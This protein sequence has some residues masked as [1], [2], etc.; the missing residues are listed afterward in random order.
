MDHVAVEM[1]DNGLCASDDVGCLDHCLSRVD[2]AEERLVI[3]PASLIVR[4]FT[5]PTFLHALDAL[6][7]SPVF[8]PPWQSHRLFAFRE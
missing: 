7:V 4:A 6:S 1:C 8:A 3:A 5:V 2:A